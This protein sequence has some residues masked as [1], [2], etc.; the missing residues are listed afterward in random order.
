VPQEI[1]Q[2]I[3]AITDNPQD[4]VRATR[5]KSLLGQGELLGW[6]GI[7]DTVRR[8]MVAPALGDAGTGPVRLPWAQML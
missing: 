6:E 1:R 3:L 5:P 2:S 8:R 7:S 4:V